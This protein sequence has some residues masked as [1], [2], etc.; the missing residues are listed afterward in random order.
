[1]ACSSS[2]PGGSGSGSGSSSGGSFGEGGG[3]GGTPA[4]VITSPTN[5]ATVTPSDTTNNV[6]VN[7]MLTNFTLAD[8]TVSGACDPK[9]DNCGHIHVYVDDNACTPNGS[10]YND[11]DDKGSPAQAIL[12]NCPTVAGMHTIRLELHH[13]DHSPVIVGGASGAVSASVMVT[14]TTGGDASSG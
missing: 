11:D 8:P 9:S 14:A 12:S 4:I 2:S 6:F 1:V 13:Q 5:G 7:F 3:G 10:P